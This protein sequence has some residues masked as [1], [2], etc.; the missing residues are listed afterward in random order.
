MNETVI[1]SPNEAKA[2]RR[3]ANTE[4][5]SWIT[6]I[7]EGKMVFIPES[8]RVSFAA[9]AGRWPKREGVR[10]RQHKAEREGVVGYFVWTEPLE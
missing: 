3:V 5:P 7:R 6:A 4:T 8:E 1:T 2:V 9:R 10:V